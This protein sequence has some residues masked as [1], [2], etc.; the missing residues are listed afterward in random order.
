MNGMFYNCVSLTGLNLSSFSTGMVT[1]MSSM[2]VD[3]SSLTSLHISNFKTSNVNSMRAMFSGCSSLTSLDLSSFK[4]G[5][6]E[7][8][9]CMFSSCASL[10]SLN[11]T[12][13]SVGRVIDMIAMFSGCSSLTSLNLS[14]FIT[15]NAVSMEN[16]F[17]NCLNLEYINM[18]QFSQEK[19]PKTE[20]MFR[21][22][23]DN[24]VVNIDKDKNY[25][26]N[27]LK[28][29]KCSKIDRSRD[30]KLN[31][32]KVNGSDGTCINNCTG[33]VEYEDKGRCYGNCTNGYIT[34][35]NNK[36][37]CKCELEKCQLCSP[38]ALQKNL[39][40]ICN[41]GYYPKEN[42]PLNIGEYI[43]CY[44]DPVGYY[45][46]ETIKLYKECYYT[47]EKCDIKG[48]ATNHKCLT[49]KQKYSIIKYAVDDNYFNCYSNNNQEETE[50]LIENNQYNLCDSDKPFKNI[51]TDECIRNFSINYIL[52]GT[53]ILNFKINETKN[54]MEKYIKVQDIVIENFETGFTSNEYNTSNLDNG[55]DEYF[56]T[57]KMYI[58]LT[59]SENQKKRKYENT[60]SIDLDSCETLLRNHYNI[61]YNEKIYIKKI[62]VIQDGMKIPKIEYDIYSKLKGRNLIRLNK[63]PCEKEKINL[64][65]PL[66]ITQK[67]EI[68]NSSSDYYNDECYSATSEYG[69]DISL[70]DRKNDF[71]NGN[72]TVCQEDCIF[73]F[74]EPYIKKVKCSCKVKESVISFA[75]MK[76]NLNKLRENF[77][78]INNIANLNFL[79]CYKTLFLKLGLIYNIGFFLNIVMLIFHIICV[80]IFYI[81][82]LNTIKGK[83]KNIHYEI[84][85]SKSIK[86][87]KNENKE[88]ENSFRNEKEHCENI[89][90]K[91]KKKKKRKERKTI[92]MINNIKKYN[93]DNMNLLTYD[94][95]L[96]YDKRTYCQYY[97]SL[98]KTNHT[99]IFSFFINNDYNSKILKVNLFFFSLISYF[100]MNALF[101]N[102][103]TMHKIYITK[104]SLNIEYQIPQI[105][106]SS[107]ISLIFDSPLK[108]L[109]LSN[110]DIL[111]FKEMKLRKNIILKEKELFKKLNIKFILYFVISFVFLLFF[112][113]YIS[114]FCAIYKNTQ[115]HLIVD[116]L[117]SFGLSLIRPFLIYLLPAIFRTI[118][119]SNPKN[120]KP[121]IFKFSKILQMM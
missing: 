114:I 34:I 9:W 36:K 84:K 67:I 97:L 54:Y 102:D 100:T 22:V 43:N 98:I 121:I 103:D 27:E 31:Q 101:Y 53:C 94:L 117:I 51:L 99:F 75:N 83:I 81:K 70:N 61:T 91:K 74:Y 66:K 110:D 111:E 7:D 32:L 116:T 23:S 88:G 109:A 85:Y 47:C 82:Q 37:I 120:K 58:F 56:K 77:M 3:C 24:I 21:N 17:Q 44:K 1:S 65:I 19:R 90:H 62:D 38:V 59:T 76:I 63:T 20:N 52:N 46:D 119:L 115:I 106:Y 64:F 12:N 15:S 104:G 11:L 39:C 78:N 28:K 45:F 29:V 113:Y 30:W 55:Y 105:I 86:A 95:A 50:E 35:E 41:T 14:S 80:V 8:M 57:E 2:F 73:S 112:W 6:V 118:A 49:C 10:T 69:T 89:I 68:L 79:K 42:D 108:I 93:D 26:V 4:T 96:K 33:D 40:T 16:M 18:R 60:T 71:I 25:F 5:N 72:R 107:L 13:F 48:D 87:T 92:N